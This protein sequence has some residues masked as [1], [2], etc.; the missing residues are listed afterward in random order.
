MRDNRNVNNEQRPAAGGNPYA[1]PSGSEARLAGPPPGSSQMP[2]PGAPPIFHNGPQPAPSQFPAQP[3]PPT[4]GQFPAPPPQFGVP[5][6]G[7]P[8]GSP[9][10]VNAPAAV[11]PRT[12]S[13]SL[14]TAASTIVLGV[15]SLIGA[16]MFLIGVLTGNANTLWLPARLFILGVGLAMIVL[17]VVLAVVS[18]RGKKGGW[19]T[20]VSALLAAF[21]VPAAI[22]TGWI[23]GWIDGDWRVDPGYDYSQI[24]PGIGPDDP[25][26]DPDID[27]PEAWTYEPQLSLVGE[28]ATL[29]IDDWDVAADASTLYLD[30]TEE[31][32][33]SAFMFFAL[34]NGSE[35][36][37]H[38]RPDQSL[39]VSEWGY[40]IKVSVEADEQ[41]VAEHPWLALL[42][43]LTSSGRVE[44]D[45]YVQAYDPTISLDISG[46][47]STITFVVHDDAVDQEPQS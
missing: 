31:R 47:D 26:D 25:F 23:H 3:A 46:S 34:E 39:T 11:P 7:L 19:L 13:E 35:L 21:L 20:L 43:E 28:S 9:P 4:A 14:S 22:L 10:P 6:Q 8:A 40:D 2:P 37:V 44:S 41:V 29:T 42:A 27:D 5:Y 12:D 45:V 36:E 15:L 16:V 24:D 32:S 38:I 33:E 30:L 18:A 1:P 17:G